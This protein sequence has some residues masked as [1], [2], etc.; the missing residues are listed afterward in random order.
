VKS[1]RALGFGLCLLPGLALLCAAAPAQADVSSWIYAGAGPAALDF[2][3]AD[4][5]RLVLELETG[6]GS[7]PAGLVFGGIFRTQSF[8][9]EGTDLALLARAATRGY[10]Q[11]GF[12]L[13]LDAGGYQRFWG[14]GSSGGTVA[15][16]LGLPWGIIARA[17]GGLGT[18][19]HRFAVFTLGLDFARLTVYRTAGT[20][21]FSNPFATDE[22]G[23]GA[24]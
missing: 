18:N 23:R 3:S 5:Q 19:D 16:G 7:P 13:A 15:L 14:E 20:N 1:R 6:L 2:G 4:R 22:Q 12:G 10:V 9:K 11:G 17:S 21:W 24:R 8:I